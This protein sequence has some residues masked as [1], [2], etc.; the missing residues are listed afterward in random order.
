MLD[1]LFALLISAQEGSF[2]YFE[3]MNPQAT[4]THL[5]SSDY[6]EMLDRTR[7]YGSPDQGWTN[8]FTFTFPHEKTD[9]QANKNVGSI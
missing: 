8:S 5:R 4:I 7:E 6:K 9:R 1:T 3:F 2:V